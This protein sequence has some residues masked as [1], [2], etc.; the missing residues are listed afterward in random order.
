MNTCAYI[1]E[2]GNWKLRVVAE[3]VGDYSYIEAATRAIEG[4]FGQRPLS[5][6]CEFIHLYDLKGQDYFDPDLIMEELPPPMF[7]IVTGVRKESE[8][9]L[10]VYLS[11]SLFANASQ[12]LN[13]KLAHQAEALEPEKV[14]AFNQMVNAQIESESAKPT[15]KKSKPKKKKD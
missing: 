10:R 7:S 4:V 15:K 13:V 11:S 1:V 8:E 5:E 14:K 12:P 2:S 6:N 3:D 9:Q